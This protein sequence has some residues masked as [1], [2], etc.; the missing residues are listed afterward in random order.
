MAQSIY[1][2]GSLRNPDI[3]EIGKQLREAGF[4]VFDE[5]FSAGP[6]ADDC[7][8][9]YEIS[10]GHTYAEALQSYEAK[11]IFNFDLK[12]LTR[13]DIGVLVMPAGKSAHLELGYMIGKGK[14]GF[15][16]FDEVPERYD[17]MYQFAQGIY[18]SPEAL[19]EGIFSRPNERDTPVQ[20]STIQSLR[21]AIASGGA[22]SF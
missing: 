3:P 19:I 2:I 7:L 13:C 21:S 4:E 17:I 6:H 5:W 16:L 22:H 14:P 10:R 1:L 12:H 20:L 8:R 9:D 15:V 18:F 11:H